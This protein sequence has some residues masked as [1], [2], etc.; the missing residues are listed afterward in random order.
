MAWVKRNLFFVV[1]GAVALIL[2]GAA[3]WYFYSKLQLNNEIYTKLNEQYQTLT[4]LNSEDPHPGSKSVD[5]IKIAKDQT[6][7]L[8]DFVEKTRTHFQRIAPIPDAQKFTDQ[9]FSSALTLTIDQL[10]H[11]ATNASVILPMHGYAF[12]FSAQRASL[13]LDPKGLAPLATQLGEVKEICEILFKSKINSL[14]NLRRERVSV[15]DASGTVT[16]YLSEK[17][18]TNDMAVITPYEV[19]FRSFSTELASVLAGFASSPYGIIVK[20]INVELAP[21]EAAAEQPQ[22]AA[23]PRYIY[24]PAP[25]PDP[26]QSRRSSEDAFRSRYGIGRPNTPQ[27]VQP[28]P[29]PQYVMPTAPAAPKTLQTALDEQKLR[30]T[31]SLS[32]VKLQPKPAIA[33]R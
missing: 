28:Q 12:S 8:R 3:G 25:T 29:Q 14:D 13:T 18:V 31:L 20:T 30:I 26:A 17:S 7:E 6:R 23:P 2:M 33:A 21:Q 5:N 32:I 1:G 15:N 10:A 4:Q 27:P 11:D 24:Q 19:S 9:E 22:E 16:D